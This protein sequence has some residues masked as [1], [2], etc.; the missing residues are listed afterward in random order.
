MPGLSPCSIR[1]CCWCLKWRWSAASPGCAA[2]GPL[3]PAHVDP[4]SPAVYESA[5]YGPM[6]TP[7][8]VPLPAPRMIGAAMTEADWEARKRELRQQA[9]EIE[10]RRKVGGE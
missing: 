3:L 5:A 6:E 10:D 1:A 9:A 7:E 2:P 8:P 4:Y